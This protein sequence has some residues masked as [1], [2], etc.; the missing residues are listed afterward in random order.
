MFKSG[1]ILQYSKKPHSQCE[2]KHFSYYDIDDVKFLKI[3]IEGTD[4]MAEGIAVKVICKHKHDGYITHFRTI[5]PLEEID[6]FCEKMS[7]ISSSHNISLF[8]KSIED[9]R[10]AAAEIAA[11]GKTST[12]Q[13]V[14]RRYVGVKRTLNRAESRYVKQTTRE[15]CVWKYL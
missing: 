15:R 12:I 7:L 6:I 10:A 5:I 9:E 14:F 4:V 8:L 3:P 1:G 13:S 2:E 11:N